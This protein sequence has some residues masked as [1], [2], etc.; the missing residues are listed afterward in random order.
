MSAKTT[1]AKTNAPGRTAAN[2]SNAAK[3]T[4]I[5]AATKNATYAGA[6]STGATTAAN[7][8]ASNQKNAPSQ[9]IDYYSA[10][11]TLPAFLGSLLSSMSS[12]QRVSFLGS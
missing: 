6:P 8:V 5:S 10:N 4:T 12:F 2:T 7:G 11:V 9:G 3:M 1:A